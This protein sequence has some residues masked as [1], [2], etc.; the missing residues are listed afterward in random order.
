MQYEISN[1]L[2][3][4]QIQG[5]LEDPVRHLLNAIVLVQ[6]AQVLLYEFVE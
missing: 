6:D 4:V 2:L 1:L 3:L 5:C